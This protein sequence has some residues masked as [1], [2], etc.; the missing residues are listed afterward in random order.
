MVARKALER[1]ATNAKP[2]GRCKPCEDIGELSRAVGL[3]RL[4]SAGAGRLCGGC[5]GFQPPDSV[6][7]II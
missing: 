3:H 1:G 6:L 2:H 4:D 7:G 5:S